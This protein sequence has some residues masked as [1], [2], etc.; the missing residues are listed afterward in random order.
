M[1]V[2][3]NEYA[4][5]MLLDDEPKRYKAG[6]ETQYEPNILHKRELASFWKWDMNLSGSKAL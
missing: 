4:D 1:D 6:L 3:L 5:T 2:Y